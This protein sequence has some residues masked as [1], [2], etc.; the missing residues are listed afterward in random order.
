LGPESRPDDKSRAIL[1][2][3]AREIPFVAISWRKH[4]SEITAVAILQ[5][6]IYSSKSESIFRKNRNVYFAVQPYAV[7]DGTCAGRL[8]ERRAPYAVASSLL[9]FS[10]LQI[11]LAA[12]L[13]PG[14]RDLFIV[15][16]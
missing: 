13:L 15:A 4:H 7:K 2:L 10:E 9:G 14:R 11:L 8:R 5:F 3:A 16:C 12:R 1:R 6:S